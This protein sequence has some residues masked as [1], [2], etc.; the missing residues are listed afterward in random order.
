MRDGGRLLTLEITMS[1]QPW[2]SV[3]DDDESL[4]A[5][6]VLLLRS[7]GIQARGFG[8]AAI[9]NVTSNGDVEVHVSD[10][11][12]GLAPA[13]EQRL[14]EPFFSTKP[15]GLE[16]GLTI[17]RSIVERHNGNLHAENRPVG[18]ALFTVT[19][20]AGEEASSHRA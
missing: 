19:L 18:G 4:R 2:V 10:T 1:E 16:M 7:A 9:S 12:P 13:V 5:A 3:I 8:S 6:V 14:F 11:G 20:P 15:H 17:V